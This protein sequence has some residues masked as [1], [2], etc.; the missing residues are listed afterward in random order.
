[1]GVDLFVEV[2][3]GEVLSRIVAD[4]VDTPAISIDAGGGSLSGL[5]KAIAAA[6][7]LGSPI[8]PPVLFGDR[9][10]RA[11]DLDWNTSFLVNPCELAPLIDAA[12]RMPPPMRIDRISDVG[13]PGFVAG[14]DL[15][16]DDN[17]SCDAREGTLDLIRGLVAERTDLP[18]GSI[19]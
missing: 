16:D 14:N 6:F 15:L 10:N 5:S 2:G 8:N 7:V 17:S 18:A 9:F 3:P 1:S 19:Q 11:F 4:A 12:D 13:D